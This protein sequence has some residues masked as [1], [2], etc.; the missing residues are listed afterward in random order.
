MRKHKARLRWFGHVWRKD[1]PGIFAEGCRGW[2]CQER[3]NGE[4]LNLKGGLRYKGVVREDMAVVELTNEDAE[5]RIKWT[6][7]NPPW[8]PLTGE[9]ER[10]S[11]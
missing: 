9:A 7:G 5:D 6:M 4:G 10:R 11:S 3:R 1:R 2:N 8:R